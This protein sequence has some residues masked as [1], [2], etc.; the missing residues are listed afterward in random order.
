LSGAVYQSK[1]ITVLNIYIIFSIL[2]Y[3][4]P[5]VMH[6]PLGLM[7]LW[8]VRSRQTW[9]QLILA[10]IDQAD[11]ATT[12]MTQTDMLRS[13]ITSLT[14]T[15][16]SMLSLFRIYSTLLSELIGHHSLHLCGSLHQFALN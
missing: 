1:Q 10:G 12:T 5:R 3:L 9:H 2:L 14:T 4:L 6:F 8:S 16:A 13:A 11:A 7:S 15:P